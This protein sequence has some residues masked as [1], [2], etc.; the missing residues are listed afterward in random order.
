L[1]IRKVASLDSQL[2]DMKDRIRLR[3]YERFVQRGYGLGREEEDWWGAH[4]DLFT[5]PPIAICETDSNF[6]VLFYLP[7][8][9]L[10]DLEILATNR[11]L[12]L[13]GGTGS[14]IEFPG[15]I[16]VR[17]FFPRQVF[18][19]VELP[20]EIDVASIVV[21]QIGDV[22]WAKVAFGSP[23]TAEPKSAKPR[24]KSKTGIRKATA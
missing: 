11:G 24:G 19:F 10:D 17:E 2:E 21:K 4:T 9:D 5:Q 6:V 7:D 13:Q 1:K 3:A 8:A 16:H 14:D 23:A 15:I 18:R 22:V 20:R 12:L